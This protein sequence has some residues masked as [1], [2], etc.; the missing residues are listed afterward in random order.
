LLNEWMG[1]QL[2]TL[3]VAV[4]V[5]QVVSIPELLKVALRRV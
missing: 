2:K 4:K 5:Y 3:E 1:L